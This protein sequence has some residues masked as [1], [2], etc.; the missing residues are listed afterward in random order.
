MLGLCL[1]LTWTSSAPRGILARVKAMIRRGIVTILA[2]L[3][4]SV[5]CG[6][7]R[8]PTASDLS[9][10]DKHVCAV[11]SD[12]SI[13]C[14]GNN[15]AGQLGDDS[16]MDSTI[17]VAVLQ[18][19]PARIVAAGTDHNCAI[20]TDGSVQCWGGNGKGQL[21]D[22]SLSNRAIAGEFVGLAGRAIGITS[23]DQFTCAIIDDGS[24][25]CWGSNDCG[26]LGLGSNSVSES[27]PV[28]V[29]GLPGNALQISAG[30]QHVCALLAGGQIQCWG[31]N[32]VGQT[33]AGFF[34]SAS[35]T[36]VA[37]SLGGQAA[38][39]AAGGDHTCA[40]LEDGSVNCWGSGAQGQLGTG[41]TTD[42]STPQPA[43]LLVGTATDVAAGSHDTC[44]IIEKS[45]QCWGGNSDGQLGEDA[46]AES[47]APININGQTDVAE[48]T[49]G[50]TRI[51]VR[52]GNSDV[53]CWGEAPAGHITF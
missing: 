34:S 6:S 42:Q 20:L 10:G 45:L 38:A 43:S 27:G 26:Q 32:E 37:V 31:C 2:S 7:S 9:A 4:A 46:S 53:D 19:P 3:V 33:G 16:T 11:L 25:Q 12:S 23:G 40:L 30:N 44:A 36:P 24:V 17:P 41:D 13:R 35:F 50:S 28:T 21:G 49:V 52:H 48:V 8:T 22:A 1:T 29:I 51:C 18:L 14:W 39:V 15:A 5:G 47:T